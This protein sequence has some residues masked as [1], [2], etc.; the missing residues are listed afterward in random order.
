MEASSS[1]TLTA[2]LLEAQF[3]GEGVEERPYIVARGTWPGNRFSEVTK[4]VSATQWK[5]ILRLTLPPSDW[6][7]PDNVWFQL[8]AHT[9]TSGIPVLDEM[10]GKDVWREIPCGLATLTLRELV[11]AHLKQ[12]PL[13]VAFVDPIVV[14]MSR[15]RLLLA[16]TNNNNTALVAPARFLTERQIR[17]INNISL[18]YGCKGLLEVKVGT[19]GS[20]LAEGIL[21]AYAA[22]PPPAQTDFVY[23]TAAMNQRA[24]RIFERVDAA[25]IDHVTESPPIDASRIARGERWPP[26]KHE[27]LITDLHMPQWES[28]AGRLFPLDFTKQDVSTRLGESSIESN[29]EQLRTALVFAERSLLGSLLRHGM[30]PS[31]F[32]AVIEKQMME[33]GEKISSSFLTAMSAIV[34]TATFVANSVS[35]GSDRRFPNI[36]WLK[37]QDASIQHALAP[38]AY[39]AGATDSLTLVA[40]LLRTKIRGDY[41]QRED[42]SFACHLSLASSL[43]AGITPLSA[44]LITRLLERKA[45]DLGNTSLG[46]LS[47]TTEFVLRHVFNCESWDIAAFAGESQTADCEDTAFGPISILET[48][49]TLSQRVL[50]NT[51]LEKTFP[52][53]AAAGKAFARIYPHGSG[54]TV[55]NEPYVKTTSDEGAGKKVVVLPRIGSADDKKW[56]EGGHSFGFLEARARLVVRHLAG[57]DLETHASQEDVVRMK[58]ALGAAIKSSAPWEFKLPPFLLEGTGPVAGYVEPAAERYAG[59]DRAD[60]MVRKQATVSAFVRNGL[61]K[62][63]PQFAALAKFARFPTQPH[64]IWQRKDPDQRVSAF[65]RT[66]VHSQCPALAAEFGQN[67]GHAITVLKA[68]R[69]RGVDIGVY[70]TA[71]DKVAYAHV[72]AG[73]FSEAEW[74]STVTPYVNSVLNQL[75]VSR[76]SRESTVTG[77]HISA[78]LTNASIATLSGYIAPR[79]TAKNFLSSPTPVTLGDPSSLP[80][81]DKN[82]LSL[83]ER[84]DESDDLAIVPLTMPAWKLKSMGPDATNEMVSALDQLKGNGTIKAYAW[85]KDRPLEQLNEMVTLMVVLPVPEKVDERVFPRPR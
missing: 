20:E 56:T 9:R 82:T 40:T 70:C 31:H 25:Y 46:K 7:E 64:E 18:N 33:K 13:R 51:N 49:R 81:A 78:P 79:L 67:L 17:V 57:L 66:Y 52:V 37:N 50:G 32:A 74:A 4:D 11:A 60:V 72:F 65:Y 83:I 15:A 59:T 77:T 23:G 48:M 10:E 55:N 22:R 45:V 41:T 3:A 53:L 73:A 14:K 34:Q 21:K 30:R 1:L 68:T 43:Q 28:Y 62:A 71:L 80:E 12:E 36:N 47:T 85:M 84:V 54:S 6:K 69:E 29:P 38:E 42:V 61:L 16:A 75:P 26:N 19:V 58:A 35:Y 5:E 39:G 76:W 24:A 27:P 63:S 8:Y 44:G 2:R